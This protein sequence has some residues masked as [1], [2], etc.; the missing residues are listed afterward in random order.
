MWQFC[1]YNYKYKI[2]MRRSQTRGVI[3][4]GTPSLHLKQKGGAL[5]LIQFLL[6]ED[7]QTLVDYALLISLI[8]IVSVLVVTIFGSHVNNMLNNDVVQYVGH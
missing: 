8:A 2:L 5:M 1:C 7:G 6:D 4:D 3:C